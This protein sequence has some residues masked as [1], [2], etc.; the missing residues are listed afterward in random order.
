MMPNEELATII[1]NLSDTDPSMR[2]TA[3]E[4]LSNADERAIYPLILLLYDDNAG[5]QDSA[6]RS[7]VAIGG[8]VTAYMALP[9]LREGPLVRNAARLILRQIG[10]P[11]VTFLRSLLRDKDDD[12]RTFAVDL[13]A[14]IGS[15]DYADEIARL[16]ETDPNPNVRAS[17]ARTL[18][19]LDY[20]PGLLALTASLRDSEWVCFSSLEA[21]A[22]MKDEASVDPIL[23]LLGNPSEALRYAAIEALGKIGSPRSSAPLIAHLAKASGMEKNAIV[24]SLVQ[25]GMTPAIAEVVDALMEM[26]SKG[27]WEERLV[28][29]A[30][31]SD[32][33]YKQAIPAILDVAGALDLSDPENE[34][35]LFTVKEALLKFGCMPAFLSVLSDPG[36]KFRGKVLAAEIVGEL[37]CAEAVPSLIDLLSIDLRDVRRAAVLALANIGGDEALTVL[38][39]CIDDRD[40]HVR[41]TAITELGRIGDLQSSDHLLRHIDVENYHDVLEETIK[42][43]LLIDARRLFSHLPALSSGVREIVARYAGDADVLL[44]LSREPDADIRVAALVSLARLRDERIRKRLYEALS[45]DSPEARKAAVIALGSLNAGIDEFSKALAD[46]DMWVRLYAVKMMGESQDA[47]ASSLVIHLLSDAEVP[48]ILSAIDALLQ[49]GGSEMA[50]IGALRNH[51]DEQV[52]ERASQVL[53]PLC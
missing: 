22:L 6:I 15:C 26:F 32:L 17:A 46:K 39:T 16:L 31:L 43:L 49:L 23:A 27:E 12:I 20:R 52:R 53:E 38:R 37:R 29:L 28:A 40:G 18:G 50:A 8:K 1:Q 30:G 35:R 42:A 10:H 33:K 45:D 36:V 11:S 25:T 47:R 4:A 2:R 48:V 3:A 34:E 5:V 14:E 51:R 9:L 44:S 13:I 21:L 7:L 41:S 24:R 19:A